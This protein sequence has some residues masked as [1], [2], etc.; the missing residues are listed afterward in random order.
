MVG[1]WEVAMIVGAVIVMAI[2][3]RTDWWMWLATIAASAWF[4]VIRYG[5]RP[6]RNATGPIFIGVICIIYTVKY[7][8][9]WWHH[10]FMS[11][12]AVILFASAV[13]IYRG[14]KRLEA[15]EEESSSALTHR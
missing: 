8:Y 12:F 1:R 7:G 2:V 11:G 13:F 6:L 14:E 10:L 15:E 3:F 5:G 9:L 4:L